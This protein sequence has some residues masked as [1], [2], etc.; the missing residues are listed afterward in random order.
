MNDIYVEPFCDYETVALWLN[1]EAPPTDLERRQIDMLI[2]FATHWIIEYCGCDPRAD[3]ERNCDL[4][5]FIAAGMV[6]RTFTE[7]AN[8]T[9][10]ISEQTIG[11]HSIKFKDG[12]FTVADLLALNRFRTISIG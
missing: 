10:G 2:T 8:S 4:L 5:Q 9:T 12:G 6:L 3:V 11:S 1:R 7:I